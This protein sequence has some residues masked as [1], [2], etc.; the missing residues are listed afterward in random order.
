MDPTKTTLTE[1]RDAIAAR[2]VS[3]A[4]AVDAYLHRIDHL[5]PP[6]N[7]YR[8]VY[9]ARARQR[10]TEVDAGR[11]TGPLAGVPIAIKDN[12]CTPYGHTTCSSKI[13]QNFEAPYTATAVQKLEDAGAIVLG[14]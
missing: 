1:L 7:A 3:A 8:E 2:K 12:L 5:N 9:E 10:A 11:I 13:L 6:L 4:Q 14:K